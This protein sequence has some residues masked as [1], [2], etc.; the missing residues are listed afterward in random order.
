MNKSYSMKSY[1]RQ[2]MPALAINISNSNNNSGYNGF[3]S[4]AIFSS[5]LL[6]SLFSVTENEENNKNKIDTIYTLEE[7]SKHKTK[8]T[9]VWVYYKDGVYDITKFIPNHPGGQDKIMLA[10]GSDIGPFWNLYQQHYNSALPI[11]ILN[12]LR[13]GTLS[14]K[15]IEYLKESQSKQDLNDPYKNDPIL[16][17]VLNYLSRKPLNA[18][19]PITLLTDSYLTPINLWFVRNHHPVVQIN[20]ENYS[21]NIN[22][23]E[24]TKIKERMEVNM[25]LTDMKNKFKSYDVI[26]TLQCGGNRRLEMTKLEKTNGK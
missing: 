21:F 7:V 24:N 16:S 13:I 25:K 1:A 22:I 8:A 4:L 23:D 2:S 19:P 20:N 11:E 18:E 6:V 9:G 10:A 26:A 17:P 3:K 12:S 15:D 14:L 5:A